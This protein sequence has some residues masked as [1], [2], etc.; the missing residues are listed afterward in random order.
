MQWSKST[1]IKQKAN[2]MEKLDAGS[3]T[4]I[5]GALW[6]TAAAF[7]YNSNKPADPVFSVEQPGDVFPQEITIKLLEQKIKYME[8]LA[9][10]K[11]N[12]DRAI[13]EKSLQDQQALFDMLQLENVE[14]LVAP[15]II[16]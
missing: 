11:R 6:F 5:I 4:V 2:N 7:S 13:I 14:T 16:D 3:I 15:A 1:A 8:E 9:E 10:A 12:L